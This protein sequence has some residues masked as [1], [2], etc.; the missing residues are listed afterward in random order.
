MNI[1]QARFNMIE[2]Q[3]R[4]WDV[5]DGAVF[6][7]P[8]LAPMR[9]EDLVPT[10]IKPWRFDRHRKFT[11]PG[12]KAKVDAGF[13]RKG[14]H[15]Q[16]LEGSRAT[17]PLTKVRARARALWRR[18]WATAPSA[19]SAWNVARPW[20]PKRFKRAY[21]HRAGLSNV[22]V[23][24][25]CGSA[26]L[27]EEG[28]FDAIMLSGSVP[29]APQVLLDQLKVGGRLIAIEGHEPLILLPLTLPVPTRREASVSPASAD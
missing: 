13:A 3:I 24:E 7:T 1:E 11:S 26:G 4:P 14:P 22:E 28:P 6:K 29:A 17:T 25:Q 9:R 27:A 19:S 21:L 18:S 16:P 12:R 23:R 15:V 8:P 5:L 10:T 2:Q 20:P